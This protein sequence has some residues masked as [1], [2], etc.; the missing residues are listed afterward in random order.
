MNATS[1]HKNVIRF[2]GFCEEPCSI[3]M[4]Y[5]CFDF[6]PFGVEKQVTTLGNF[7]HLVDV[8]FEFTSL[9]DVLPICAKNVVT[10]LEYL[11]RKNIAHR[12]LKPGNI[13]VCNTHYRNGGVIKD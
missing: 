7:L 9:A 13:L 3:S 6:S 8:E 4:E 5:C 1:G 10:G 12:D 2:F 11:H